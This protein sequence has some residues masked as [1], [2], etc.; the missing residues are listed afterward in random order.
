MQFSVHRLWRFGEGGQWR[1]PGLF[2]LPFLSFLPE[3]F[4]FQSLYSR[5]HSTASNYSHW[6]SSLS[7]WGVGLWRFSLCTWQPHVAGRLQGGGEG[8]APWG[9]WLGMEWLWF[10]FHRAKSKRGKCGLGGRQE[11]PPSLIKGCFS[12]VLREARVNAGGVGGG[13]EMGELDEK[14]EAAEWA[15][16]GSFLH[17]NSVLLDFLQQLSPF[18]ALVATFQTPYKL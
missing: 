17:S 16:V 7:K 15:E 9:R 2:S 3:T 12:I 5:S 11:N 13:R 10:I 4:S 14:E 6:P 8:S 18:S 1:G